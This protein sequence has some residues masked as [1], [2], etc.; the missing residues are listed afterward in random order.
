MHSQ[1]AHC[2]RI[3]FRLIECTGAGRTTDMHNTLMICRQLVPVRGL[4]LCA[5]QK[6]DEKDFD[7]V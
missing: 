4:K 2:V 1:V 3:Y 5:E 6:E 7:S